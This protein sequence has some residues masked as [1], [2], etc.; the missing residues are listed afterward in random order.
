M[1]WRGS[2]TPTDRIFACLPYLLP[3]ID[4]LAFSVFFFRQF[5][6]LQVVLLP[7]LPIISIYS[8][9]PFAGWIV[10]FAVYFGVVRNENINH[11]IRF[12]AMQAILIG[13]VLSLCSI[14]I[15]FILFPALGSSGLIIETLF[16]VIFLGG[17][18]AIIYSVV[19]TALGR[20]A[21]IPSLSNAVYMQVR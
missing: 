3:L 12:N 1:S 11:F 8:A 6:A 16:N 7:F 21:E 2:V 19:Q 17:M 13:I 10:F 18:A 5:P 15:Q 4:A 20:Y 9:I 14:V